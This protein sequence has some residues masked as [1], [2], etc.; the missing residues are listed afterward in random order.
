M[1]RDVSLCSSKS[2]SRISDF[3][4]AVLK[5]SV[6]ARILPAEPDAFLR[7]RG[8]LARSA[9]AITPVVLILQE[10][11][12]LPGESLS[13]CREVSLCSSR[14][15]SE[16][17]DFSFAVLKSSVRARILPAEPDAFLRVRGGLARSALA[18]TPVALILQESP[19]LPGESLSLCREAS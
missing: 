5:S 11:P 9:L 2:W 4:F 8:G 15:W 17:S 1:C 14:S 13:L 12:V 6:R 19:V 3:S 10:S 18:I 16:V 7:V